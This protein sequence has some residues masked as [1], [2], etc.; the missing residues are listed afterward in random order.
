MMFVA[1]D[2]VMSKSAMRMTEIVERTHK[3]HA[4][5]ES[6]PCTCKGQE[7]LACQTKN[8]L[9]HCSASSCHRSFVRKR[10]MILEAASRLSHARPL[11]LEARLEVARATC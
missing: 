7:G 9:L 11:Q 10:L 2:V 3:E 4:L 5:I 1:A 6:S 8:L